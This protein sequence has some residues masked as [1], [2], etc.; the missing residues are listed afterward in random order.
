M[1]NTTA[2]LITMAKRGPVPNQFPKAI[3]ENEAE[4]VR[5]VADL[6]R[7]HGWQVFEQPAA[8]DLGADLIAEGSGKKYVFEIK[9]ASEGRRDRIIPLL[10]QAALQAAYIS[11]SLPG[12]PLPVAVVVAS[13]LP[14]PI[15]E[16]AGAFL[17]KHA[18]DVAV[19][20]MDSE[21]FRSFSGFDLELL[22]SE[23]RVGSS[24]PSRKLRT[25]APQLFSDLNQW[26]LKVLL[27]PRIPES[28]LSAPRSHYEGASQLAAAAGVSVMSGFRFVEQ[29]SKEGFLEQSSSRLRL[30]RAKEL[31]NRWLGAGQKRNL[32]VP[33]R[34]ILQRGKGALENALRSYVAASEIAPNQQ[35]KSRKELLPKHPRAC[36]GLFAAAEQLGVG[37]VHGAEPHVYVER[38]NQE[39]LSSLGL[40]AKVVDS[41][42]DVYVRIPSNRESVFRGL[43]LKDGVPSSD[44]IQVWLDV[45]GYPSRGKEQAD[46]IYR[47]ILA[48]A[49]ES[50]E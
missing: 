38:M 17:G 18:P 30:V 3:P 8:K 9:W 19:G 23:R 47:R 29:F 4:L 35:H 49:F 40:S 36:L 7:E 45:Y 22:S 41:Q 33:M 48:P 15:A 28:Y 11:K 43:V 37:F 46:L 24:V 31:V 42:G 34:F 10:S 14:E 2:M 39:L 5:L 12:N 13:Y 20:L 50:N 26:M 32:E 6:L 16:Q 27:A 25:H 1:V 44:V 21:G